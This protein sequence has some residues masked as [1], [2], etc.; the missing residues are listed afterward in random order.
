MNR[1]REIM[2]KIAGG[3]LGILLLQ[4]VAWSAADEFTVMTRNLY[5]GADLTPAMAARN[6]GDFMTAVS[7]IL[8]TIAMNNFSERAEALAAEI[9]EER[10]HL[11]GLQEV[12]NFTINGSNGTPP[13]RDHLA[14][15][16]A[17]L[18]AQGVEYQV[19]AVV[20]NLN[21][22]LPFA[23]NLIGVLDRDVILA[24]SD[25][26]TEVIDFG[27]GCN[28][29]EAGCNYNVV[30]TLPNPLDPT[31]PPISI[32]RGFVGV[33]AGLPDS[34]RVTFV[35]THLEVREVGPFGLL[36]ALQAQE[37]LANLGN[38]NGPVI[39]VGDFNSDPRDPVQSS[40]VPPYTQLVA[41][42]YADAWL[43]HRP[44]N[45]NGFTCCQNEDLF[46][47]QSALYER[48]DLIL[49]SEVPRKVKVDLV[50]NQIPDKTY[51][52]GLWPSDH[53]GVAARLT[54][55]H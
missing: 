14:D 40:I 49:T 13:F 30:A 21:L 33:A 8:E 43:E 39:L 25:V 34:Q 3:L 6:P 50:G 29:S 9:V 17:A 45:P 36:Q 31:L 53:A 44:G 54:L 52:S 46:N 48:I 47:P 18:Q 19:A 5:L 10:P 15:L 41:A 24:R 11:V 42:R 4:G 16:L 26:A 32:E 20:N 23:G 1:K 37:L 38:L 51:P 27:S 7:G 55:A 22:Q 12:Y 35:N 2:M 28:K